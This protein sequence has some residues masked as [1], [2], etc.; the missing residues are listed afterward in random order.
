MAA[1]TSRECLLTWMTAAKMLEEGETKYLR[2]GSYTIV[3]MVIPQK[4][5]LNYEQLFT[6]PKN[7]SAPRLPH[8]TELY[9]IPVTYFTEPITS[10]L[11]DQIIYIP[12]T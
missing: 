8:F 12:L 6:S 7:L 10:S 4:I 5:N 11:P 9:T 3:L 1:G 2:G